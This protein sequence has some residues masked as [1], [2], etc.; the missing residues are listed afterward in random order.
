L[1]RETETAVFK[2]KKEMMKNKLTKIIPLKA[3]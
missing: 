3:V 1:I 2:R